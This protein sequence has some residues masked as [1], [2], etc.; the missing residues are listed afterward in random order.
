MNYHPNFFSSNK[1]AFRPDCHKRLRLVRRYVKGGS[2]LDIGCSGGFFSFA[3][4]KICDPIIAIDKEADLI[5]RCLAIQKKHGTNIEFVVGD[6]LDAILSHCT[7]RWDTIFYMSTHHHVVSQEGWDYANHILENLSRSC[8]RMF[9]DMGQKDEKKCETHKWW[10]QLPKNDD[11]EAW[12][13][14]YFSKHTPFVSVKI[15]GSTKIHGT[16]RLLWKLEN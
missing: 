3:F 6:A 13:R 5:D 12:L 11:Q 16:N 10:Q 8:R 15:I 9:F 4:A 14:Q 7:T 2:L 1:S